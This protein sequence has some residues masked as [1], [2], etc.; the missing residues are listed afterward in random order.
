MQATSNELPGAQA[1]PNSTEPALP[2]QAPWEARQTR[3]AQAFSSII[4]VMM[5][6]ET[7]RSVRLAE[8]EHMVIP[9]VVSGQWRLGHTPEVSSP[10]DK[11]GSNRTLGQIMVPSAVVL[12][13]QVSDEIDKRMSNSEEK[14]ILL[15][16]DKWLS[17]S[18]IWVVLA[19][20]NKNILARLIDQ[21]RQSDFSGKVVKLRARGPDGNVVIRTLG[22]REATACN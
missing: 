11:V 22:A 19:A 2:G 9:A 18:H 1:K 7:Y 4:A 16:P 14:G 13:A 10:P 5:R 20:G 8:L 17:G 12:W 15:D 6:D 21:L 3:W